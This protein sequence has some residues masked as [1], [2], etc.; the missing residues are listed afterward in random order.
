MKKLTGISTNKMLVILF[1]GIVIIPGCRKVD[2]FGHDDNSG[3]KPNNVN[4]STLAQLY[5]AVNNPANAGK[6][7]VL[8]PGTYTLDPT[9]ANAG[10]LELLEDMELQGQE[11]HPEMVIIDASL[12]PGSSFNPPLGIPSART[13]AIRMGRGSNKIEWLTVIGNASSQALS[14]I[15]TDL[16]WA[17]GTSKVSVSHSIITGGRIGID[18]RNVGAVNVGRVLE[19]EI[20]DNEVKENLVQ[21]GQGIEVQNANGAKKA[22][23]RALF[24]GN[25]VHG[26]KIGMRSFNNSGNAGSV[27]SGSI[28]IQ[29]YFDRFDENGVGI[30]L[31]SGLNQGTVAITANHNFLQFEAHNSSFK[32][33]QGIIPP[34][35]T[36]PSPGGIYLVGGFSVIGGDASNNNLEVN[37]VNCP[38]TGNQGPGIK[39]YGA[40]SSISTPAGTNN[41]VKIKLE[42][43]SKQAVVETI[44]S[45]PLDA[46]GT[47]TVAVH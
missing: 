12:L 24:H 10:R 19:A 18:I 43:I 17:G 14:V 4:I 36:D 41:A 6:S 45:L 29:S 42:G 30:E 23:I 16:A 3:P 2:W 40:F 7:I 5:D 11:G 25:N 9:Y 26:N 31:I 1:I 44:P 39:A 37:L 28:I 47:N 27:D 20:N 8:A 33:N 21:F 46:G 35:V 15:D 22:I 34:D 38:I 13:G 32:N